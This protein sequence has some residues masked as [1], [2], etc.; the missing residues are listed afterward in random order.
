[1][2]CPV[3]LL[4]YLLTVLWSAQQQT[5]GDKSP[6]SNYVRVHRDGMC[7]W[8]PLF[9]RS[10]THCTIDVTWY[11]FDDQRCSLIFESWK[12]NTNVMNIS[13]VLRLSDNDYHY[14]V[15]DEWELQGEP[16]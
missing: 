5:V 9:E 13:A 12:Y 8:W 3:V 6:Q 4:T 11:P 14:V 16:W 2:A 1:M 10:V 7:V 15:N